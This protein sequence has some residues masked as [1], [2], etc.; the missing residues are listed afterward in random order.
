MATVKKLRGPAPVNILR[1]TARAPKNKGQT[2]AAKAK[3]KKAI[4]VK[5][6]AP[7]KAKKAAT[8]KKKLGGAKA[9]PASKKVAKA[10]GDHWFAKLSK[11]AQ[12]AYIKTHPNSKYAKGA[13][14]AKGKVDSKKLTKVSATANKAQIKSLQLDH[15][16]ANK[17]EVKAAQKHNSAIHKL[18]AVEGK[19]AAAKTPAMKKKLKAHIVAAKGVL[20]AAKSQHREAKRDLAEKKKA[21]KGHIKAVKKAKRSDGRDPNRAVKIAPRAKKTEKLT[22]KKGRVYRGNSLM[23]MSPSQLKKGDRIAK[24]KSVPGATRVVTRKSATLKKPSANAIK[25]SAL[26]AKIANMPR[27]S[28]ADARRKVKAKEQLAKLMAKI[29]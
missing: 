24:V 19:H 14:G 13:K 4:P 11:A 1:G 15:R 2:H 7:S 26:K 29:K 6:K 25:V 22:V 5:A 23:K 28:P 8:P 9:K 12:L 3:A 17:A 21:A 16:V 10:V 18:N 27:V 20:K